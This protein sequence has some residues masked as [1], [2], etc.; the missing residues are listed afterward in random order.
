MAYSMY[1]LSCVSWRLKN[2]FLK[3]G[4]KWVL[5]A[6]VIFK[7][8]MARNRCLLTKILYLLHYS[9]EKEM[10][11]L[12]LLRQKPS[13]LRMV[14]LLQSHCTSPVQLPGEL[15]DGCVC[16]CHKPE[17]K[18]LYK[19]VFCGCFCRGHASEYVDIIEFEGE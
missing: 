15:T 7:S 18:F 14:I 17:L 16:L 5:N 9:L 8:N 13:F 3:F 12:N 2:L 6:S 1:A 4:P 10:W 19:G 11:L